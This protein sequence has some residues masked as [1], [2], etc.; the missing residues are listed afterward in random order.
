[1]KPVVLLFLS[2]MLVSGCGPKRE[3]CQGQVFITLKSRETV[4]MSLVTVQLVESNAARVITKSELDAYVVRRNSIREDLENDQREETMVDSD[5]SELNLRISDVKARGQAY[6][7][8]AE[9]VR[10][11]ALRYNYTG[12]KLEIARL[13]IVRLKS[14]VDSNSNEALKMTSQMTGLKIKRDATK[15]KISASRTELDAINLAD[16]LFSRSFPL[17][18]TTVTDA[19]G[20]FQFEVP[21]G[22]NF[23]VVA[24]SSRKVLDKDETYHW[25]VPLQRGSATMLHNGNLFESPTP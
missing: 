18:G 17:R 5:I 16:T 4:K 10:S 12:E 25:I 22:E 1:M 15:A 13:S 24:V 19:D 6:R 23:T 20:R 11:A 3:I 2:L 14:L 21:H 7:D 8:E 9:Q